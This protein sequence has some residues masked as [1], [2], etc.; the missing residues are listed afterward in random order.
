MKKMKKK[1]TKRKNK[2]KMTTRYLLIKYFWENYL[3]QNSGMFPK[4]IKE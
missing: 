1:M 2:K 4:F 3:V